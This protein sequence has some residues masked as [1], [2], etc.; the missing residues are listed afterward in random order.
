[1]ATGGLGVREASYGKD[2]ITAAMLWRS[3]NF[4]PHGPP[5]KPTIPVELGGAVM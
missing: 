3:G 1:V 5:P 4:P 2:T